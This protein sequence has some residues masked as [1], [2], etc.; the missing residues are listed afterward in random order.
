M[1]DS[2]ACC[3]QASAQTV[4]VNCTV[5]GMA[6]QPE[7]QSSANAALTTAPFDPQSF[8]QFQTDG[9]AA[10]F[11]AMMSP[12]QVNG[13]VS[14]TPVTHVHPQMMTLYQPEMD[15]AHAISLPPDL[16]L[17]NLPPRPPD[18]SAMEGVSTTA[19]DAAATQELL[20]E[21]SSQNTSFTLDHI[22]G[23]DGVDA[24][25]LASSPSATTV[26]TNP[27]HASS[28]AVNGMAPSFSATPSSLVS[29]L[30]GVDV[31]Q[32]RTESSGSPPELLS[33]GSELGFSSTSSGPATS[34][35]DPGFPYPL[36]D[37]SP[38]AKEDSPEQSGS[39][40]LFTLGTMLKKSVIFSMFLD[41]VEGP[42]R[43]LTPIS[44]LSASHVRRALLAKLAIWDQPRMRNR[45]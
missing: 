27:S 6:S 41:A 20:A 11:L 45:S 14:A 16:S 3:C 40:H 24:A 28:P 1:F 15:P 34:S 43:S 26:S 44:D 8:Q 9:S 31:P 36:Y 21:Y 18:G 39:P 22:N 25:R 29:A 4:L 13:T 33:S 19:V 35:L 7:L 12:S 30:N 42:Y 23:L 2:R 10:G 5:T 32:S 17:G 38:R 37:A